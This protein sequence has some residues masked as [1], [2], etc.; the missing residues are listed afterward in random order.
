MDPLTAWDSGL[1]HSPRAITNPSPSAGADLKEREQ[2]SEA[3]VEV[4]VQR[5]RGMMTEIGEGPGAGQRAFRG[6]ADPSP[7]APTILYSRRGQFLL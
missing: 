3:E 4:F 2:M 1:G 5:L 6:T 7:T